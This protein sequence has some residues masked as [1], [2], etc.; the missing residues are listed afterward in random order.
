[1]GVRESTEQWSPTLFLVAG[2]LLV[3]HAAISGVR[4]FTDVA[5]PADVFGPVGFLL[6]LVG[7]YGLY[8]ELVER[9]PK[10]ARSGAVVAAVA[11]VDY[12]VIAA[13]TFGQLV[14][15]LPPI[16]DVLPAV[17]F[18]SHLVAMILTYGLFGVAALRTDAHPRPVGFLL[19]VFPILIVVQMANAAVMGNPGAGAFLVGSV[20]A[21]VHLAIGYS[22]GTRSGAHDHGEPTGDVN[23][24]VMRD[25]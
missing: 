19:L 11:T 9:A 17:F 1:M 23:R 10:L 25:G 15:V 2:V 12:V 22:L 7:L 20:L 3:G 8:P 6:A 24:G 18:V 4:A 13:S 21:V 5:T 16:S 14:G